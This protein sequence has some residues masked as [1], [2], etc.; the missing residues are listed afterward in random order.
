MVPHA[1]RAAARGAAAG[2]GVGSE[3]TRGAGPARQGRA[4]GPAD[5]A[6]GP[7]HGRR[8][9]AG[10]RPRAGRRPARQGAVH[11]GP[12]REGGR[13][14]R[15]DR[16]A[17]VPGRARTRRRA[18]SRATRRS[19]TTAQKNFERYKGLQA[20]NLVAGAAGR[21]DRRRRSASSRARS[22]STRR[23]SRARSCNLDYARIKSPLDG[24][25]GVRQV[26]AGN[27]VHATDANGIVV[28]TAIDPAA[29]FF[30]V[31][32]DRLAAIAAAHGAAA[33]SRSRS[34]AATAPAGSATGK[35]AVIDNQVNQ[36][37]AT[38]RL[39]ALVPN[40]QRAAVAERVRQGAHAGRDAQ[41]RARG[42]DG[43]DAA[44]P[45][46]RRS[47]TSSAPTRRAQMKPV[48]VG[49]HTGEIAVI[50]A[51]A[52]RAASRSSIEGAEPA[53]ARA[54]KVAPSARRT[55]TRDAPPAGP[56]AGHGRMA[57]DLRAVHPPAGRDDADDVRPAARRASPATAAAGRR[58]AAG[59]LPDDRRV[60]AAARR[61]AP[62]RWRRR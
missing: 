11:R 48:T 22:R 15:A 59:R 26:D 34:T 18:R 50:A 13:R 28:I 4:E 21:G 10:H 35:L 33:T 51:R 29:V 40:P 60:D 24:I 44:R 58:A 52:S 1:W 38:L 19:S 30:T 23:R 54:R 32:Q 45:A 17:A 20:Q 7:R 62:R 42:P 49:L 27:L 37:T 12:G 39:K 47:S 8:G 31:P 5:L 6:R 43:R 2:A 25:T 41:G 36:T 55:A 16:S 56:A 61:V 46:G 9:P 57:V 14:A 53:A 3:R